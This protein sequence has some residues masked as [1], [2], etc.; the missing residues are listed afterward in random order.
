MIHWGSLR[1]WTPTASYPPRGCTDT[2][3]QLEPFW[4][5]LGFNFMS[6]YFLMSSW[7]SIFS[8]F[9]S[10]LEA[11]MLPKSF[12]MLLPLPKNNPTMFPVRS[13]NLAFK[14]TRGRGRTRTCTCTDTNFG[15][16]RQHLHKHYHDQARWRSWERMRHWI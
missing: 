9:G 14:H 1:G 3:S 16:K 10:I 6:S 11:K 12:K 7:P 5:P 13:P 2:P 4:C 15:Q 8:N